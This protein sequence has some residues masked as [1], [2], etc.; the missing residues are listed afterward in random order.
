[1]PRV[2]PPQKPKPIQ[3]LGT[4]LYFIED[5]VIF[6]GGALKGSIYNEDLHMKDLCRIYH[7]LG[8]AIRYLKL[9]ER[10]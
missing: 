4:S 8:K 5:R 9:K 7:W 10:K 2:R 1:M 6:S 3:V